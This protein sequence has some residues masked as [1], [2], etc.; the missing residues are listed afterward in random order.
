MRRTLF[1]RALLEH[2]VAGMPRSAYL[3][4]QRE[5]GRGACLHEAVE[6]ENDQGDDEPRVPDDVITMSC[7]YDGVITMSRG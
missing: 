1:E 4:A 7:D 6:G 3:T 2:A 5:K